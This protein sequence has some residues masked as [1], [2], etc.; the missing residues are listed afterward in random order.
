MA[1]RSQ[2]P[3]LADYEVRLLEI[4]QQLDAAQLEIILQLAQDLIDIPYE[5]ESGL[6]SL[7]ISNS[8][9]H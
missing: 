2:K 9:L 4:A 3:N 5:T 7:E 6:G 8:L 1:T